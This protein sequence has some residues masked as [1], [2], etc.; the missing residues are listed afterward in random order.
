[1]T[2]TRQTEAEIRA[3]VRNGEEQ[4]YWVTLTE[5]GVFWS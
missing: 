4:E 5:A 1:M 2:L 3:L